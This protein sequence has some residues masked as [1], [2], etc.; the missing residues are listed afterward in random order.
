MVHHGGKVHIIDEEHRV[1]PLTQRIFAVTGAAGV[2]MV[3]EFTMQWD[4]ALV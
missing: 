4:L 1:L 2:G 3:V